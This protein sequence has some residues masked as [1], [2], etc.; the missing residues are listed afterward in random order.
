MCER[1]W[2]AGLAI[3][4]DFIREAGVLTEFELQQI[5][6]RVFAPSANVMMDHKVGVM[7]LQWMIA[8]AALYAGLA[9]DDPQLVARAMY[10]PHGILNL[11]DWGYLTMWRGCGMRFGLSNWHWATW[12]MSS[13]VTCQT[14]RLS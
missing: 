2:L 7:N 6:D 12:P 8:S 3:G 9:T 5:R 13:V 14:T 4:L 11:V 10:D 1:H